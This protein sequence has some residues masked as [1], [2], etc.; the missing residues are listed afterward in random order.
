MLW[1]I[2]LLAIVAWLFSK[3]DELIEKWTEER[4]IN[5]KHKQ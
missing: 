5:N 1:G 4:K 3:H 2:V